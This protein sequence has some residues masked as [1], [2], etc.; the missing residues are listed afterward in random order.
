VGVCAGEGIDVESIEVEASGSKGW[1]VGCGGMCRRGYRRRSYRRRARRQAKKIF[2]R[3]AGEAIDVES[4]E[5]EASGSKGW[6]VGCGSMCRRGY[7]RRIY[8]SRGLGK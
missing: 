6:E 7:R 1:G 2:L 4:I 5:V 3:S 8:R